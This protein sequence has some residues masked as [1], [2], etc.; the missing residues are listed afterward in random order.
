VGTAVAAEAVRRRLIA[1]HRVRTIG[2]SVDRAEP[3]TEHGPDA[4]ARARRAL[5]VPQDGVVVGAVGRLAY[6]KAPQDFVAAMVALG[7]PDVTAIWIGDGPDAAEVRA[8]AQKAIPR[9]RVLFV[10]ER[11][12]IPQV[13]PAFDVFALPSRYEGLPIAI[14]EAMR[15]GIPV[16]ATAVNS[17]PDVVV[18]GETGLLV[19]P[20]RPTDLARAVAHL[21]DHP[22]EARRIADA[23]RR[24]TFDQHDAASLG[25]ALTAAYSG[26]AADA[27]PA[28]VPALASLEDTP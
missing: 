17:V 21:L 22:A 25:A 5:G 28:P 15:C 19:P 6:Q 12:D 20:H 8:L 2:V 3:G 1:P 7:R 26:A 27:G 10:G 24:R 13:L 11:A 9:A 14:V 18:P 16:V 4:R 23:A